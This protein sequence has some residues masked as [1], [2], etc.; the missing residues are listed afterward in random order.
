MILERDEPSDEVYFIVDGTVRVVNF[1]NENREMVLAD[2]SAG[3]HFGEFAA[4][5]RKRRSARVV[6]GGN[7]EVAVLTRE[8]FLLLLRQS[9]P[10][11]LRLLDFFAAKIRSLNEKVIACGAMAPRQRVCL[12][13]LCLAIPHPDGNE[14]WMVAPLPDHR[15]IAERA[16]VGIAEVAHALTGLARDGVIERRENAFLIKDHAR[17]R[18]LTMA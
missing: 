2:L 6:G 18:D 12:D 15:E 5:D 17:L 3:D 10:V 8:D 14:G 13:L 16:G 7:C 4:V 11:A 9:H 1:D